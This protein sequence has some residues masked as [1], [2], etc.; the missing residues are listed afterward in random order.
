MLEILHRSGR[1]SLGLEAGWKRHPRK[2]CSHVV[3]VVNSFLNAI[4][5]AAPF[6]K[7][8][9]EQTLASTN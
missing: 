9:V 6:E 2:G 7:N 1:R 8:R 3:G 5:P 4:M